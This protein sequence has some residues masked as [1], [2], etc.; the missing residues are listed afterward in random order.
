[1]LKP[2]E[3]SIGILRM[4]IVKN[5]DD[6]M[7]SQFKPLLISTL[8]SSSLLLGCGGS[9]STPPAVITPTNQSPAVTVSGES[10]IQEGQSLTLIANA[11]D[12]DGSISSVKWS[13]TSTDIS[14]TGDDTTS[15]S[16]TAPDVD[17]DTSITLDVLVTDNDGATATQSVTITITRKV[18]SVTITGLVTDNIISNAD[19]EITIGGQDF[20]ATADENGVY[21][22]TIN[23]DESL[24][25]QLVQ[26]RALGD[27]SIN[28]EV[29]FISQLGSLSSLIAQ[30]GSDR[31]LV[32]DENF[33][34]N[35]TNV[36]T[37]EYALMTR[38]GTTPTTDTELSLAIESVNSDEKN[39]LAALIK[40]VVDNDGFNLPSSVTSTLNLVSDS[41]TA[42][43]FEQDVITQNPTLI[44]DTINTIINDDS[45]TGESKIVGTW[46]IGTDAITFTRSGHYVHITTET[47]EEDDKI[48][49]EIGSYSW[50]KTTG[51]LSFITREDSNGD[52]GLHDEFEEPFNTQI[53]S[54]ATFTVT[55]DTLMINE[56]DE[57]FTATRLASNSNPF[58]GGFY[59]QQT[60]FSDDLS[61]LVTVDDSKAI[62]LFHLNSNALPAG[63]S[64]LYLMREYSYD[65]QSSLRIVHS[66]KV[67][68]DGNIDSE[69][70]EEIWR[71]LTNIQGDVISMTTESGTSFIKKSH[72]T[73][74]QNY[75]VDDDIIGSFSG[76][77]GGIDFN[78]TINADGTG[79]GSSDEGSSSLEWKIIFGQLLLTLDGSDT[80]IWS[81]TTLADDIWQFTVVEYADGGDFVGSSAGTLTSSDIVVPAPAESDIVGTWGPLTFSSDGHYVHMHEADPI[82][83]CDSDGYELG[84]YVWN[85]ITG[86]VTVTTSEDTNGCVGLHDEQ[87]LNTPFEL[88][89]TIQ[90]VGESLTITDISGE[91]SNINR[92]ISDANP[93]VGAYYEGDFGDDFFLVV[94]QDNGTF[95]ELAHDSS[96]LG[97][98]AGTY[99]W[100]QNSSLLDFTSI[101]FSQWGSTPDQNIISMQ[102][103]IL[104]WKDG[105]DAGVMKRT[106]Q[107]TEQPYLTDINQV[108]G[109][110]RGIA[111]ENFGFEATLNT[112]FSGVNTDDT[113]TYTFEWSIQFGQLVVDYGDE[114]TILT[115]TAISAN[116]LAFSVAEFDLIDTF[117]GNEVGQV[118]YFT[119]TW[120][121]N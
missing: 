39:T 4:L 111:N 7:S 45:L 103:D 19:V 41:A 81:P 119:H 116:T 82:E 57:T 99:N 100:N 56:G 38:D 74:T 101:A 97:L 61:M 75:L 108:I 77:N 59:L 24:L 117:D 78:L 25:N 83:D 107:S 54:V 86:V 52:S 63:I 113:G 79:Q 55:G 68:V 109:N 14:L 31:N 106:H 66:Q 118:E 87:P 115:P 91:I 85:E 69:K 72:T 104:I 5:R 120:T 17:N 50:N 110:F 12:A 35:I 92:I 80:Q 102:G 37:A 76:T 70:T 58:V 51:S 11:S 36:T 16:F 98:T 10:T 47:P 13:T 88:D 96:E 23:F 65:A 48:G 89:A 29:E 94:F 34:V 46:K 64:Y 22:I 73:T 28:P 84:T 6:K 9:D 32:E 71:A 30:A 43:A 42:S 21:T 18:S 1:M 3:Y 40:I 53:V 49:Y 20:S 26:I 15:V 8:L 105:E 121:R 33:G 95:M 112:N 90:V 114:I 62:L 2:I 27:S 93:L 67:Y 60:N 44:T